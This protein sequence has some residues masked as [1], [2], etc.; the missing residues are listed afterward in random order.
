IIVAWLLIRGGD[1]E[2]NLN[3]RAVYLHVLGDLL[4]SI[5]AIVAAVL[6]LIFQWGWADPLASVLVAFLVLISGVRVTKDALHVLM[7]GTPKEIDL[8]NVIQKIK[9]V[10]GV[11]GLHDLH[12]WSI[13]SGHHALSAH[14]VVEGGMTIKDRKSVVQQLEITLSD[15]GIHHVTIQLENKNH[16]HDASILCQAG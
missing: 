15:E 11:L 8:E 12:V 4:G 6:I 1:T 9:N 7:E 14:V 10:E 16:L 2:E 3:L 13:T 5:G